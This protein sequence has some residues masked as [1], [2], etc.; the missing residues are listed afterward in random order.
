MRTCGYTL[1]DGEGEEYPCDRLATSWRWYQ[2]VPH[3]DVLTEACVIHEN[4]GGRRMHEA[5]TIV[6]Q[7]RVMHDDTIDQHALFCESHHRRARHCN[8]WR[9][10]LAGILKESE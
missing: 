7:V 2:D 9:A 1:V 6:D 8:C 10:V 4:E 3:E 5:E